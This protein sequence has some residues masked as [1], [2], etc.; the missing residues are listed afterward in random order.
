MFARLLL[1]A[2]PLGAAQVQTLLILH[3]AASSLGFYTAAGVQEAAV[4]VGRHPHEMAFSADGRF[5]YTTDNGTMSIE[6][7]GTGGNSIS[8]IDLKD[9]KR[10]ATVALGRFRRPHGIDVHPTTGHVFVSCE[11]PDQLLEIDPAKRAIVR[12]WDTGGKTAHMVV[13]DHPGLWAYVSHSNSSNV[14]A[15]NLATGKVKLIPTGGR[16]E[17]SV[18]SRDGRYVYVANR[19]GA[20][21]TII[22]TATQSAVGSIPTGK[23]PVRIQVTPDGKTL[24]YALI[25][26]PAIEFADTATRK[27]TGRVPVKLHK[28]LVSL[29][30]SADGREAFAADQDGDTVFVVSVPDRKLARQFKVPAGSGPDPVIPMRRP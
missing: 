5:A 9:R 26:E 8:I 16:P 4:P 22:D 15:L 10:A 2:L 17:G 29:N 1:A 6:Q 19:E 28:E 23:G 13:L 11:L 18:L 25:H 21:V 24:V 30:L 3:K 7:A 20:Q 14:G 12:T 27:V